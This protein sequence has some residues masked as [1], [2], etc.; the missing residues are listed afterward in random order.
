MSLGCGQNK[1]LRTSSQAL[2]HFTDQTTNQFTDSTH[3]KI[4]VA[5]RAF[6]LHSH[7]DIHAQDES[8][9]SVNAWKSHRTTTT[10]T[11]GYVLHINK[12]NLDVTVKL[13]NRLSVW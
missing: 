1:Y 13:N 7:I 6:I 10:T 9:Y 2:D 8:L 4:T 12:Q 3:M 11:T 5:A